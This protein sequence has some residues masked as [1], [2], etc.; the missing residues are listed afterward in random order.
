VTW[1]NDVALDND[2][3]PLSAAGWVAQ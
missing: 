2:E 3:N 1:G